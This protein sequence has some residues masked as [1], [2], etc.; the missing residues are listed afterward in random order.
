MYVMFNVCARAACLVLV[1]VARRYENL[2]D[3]E[4]LKKG[5]S[6]FE[7]KIGFGMHTFAYYECSKCSK[8]YYGGRHECADDLEAE[9]AEGAFV[10]RVGLLCVSLRVR[11]CVCVLSLIH[12]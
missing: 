7:D 9:E 8:P 6:F 5:G 1:F 10:A 2:A 3:H 4:A 12:I 11:V